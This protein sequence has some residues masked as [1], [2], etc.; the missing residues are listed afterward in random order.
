MTAA[1]TAVGDSAPIHHQPRGM[2]L[3]DGAHLVDTAA[4]VAAAVAKAA[5]TDNVAPA[6]TGDQINQAIHRT[7]WLP[8]YRPS[9]PGRHR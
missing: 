6:L 2:L 1:A 8:G 3:P 4:I 9:I 7:R 5:V